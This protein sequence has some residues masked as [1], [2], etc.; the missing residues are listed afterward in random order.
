MTIRPATQ[1]DLQQKVALSDAKRTQYEQHTPTFWRKAADARERQTRFF[2]AL[3]GREQAIALIHDVRC[4]ARQ[5]LPLL[6][7]GM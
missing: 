5:V 2:E 7:S 1:A 6:P 3:L 4:C